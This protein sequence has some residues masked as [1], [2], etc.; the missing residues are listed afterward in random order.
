MGEHVR[1]TR[2]GEE[3]DLMQPS[4]EVE[5]GISQVA[6]ADAYPELAHIY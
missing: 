4:R 3:G 1:A 5:G 2:T 6:V